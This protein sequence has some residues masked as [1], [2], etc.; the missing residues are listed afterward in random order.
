MQVFTFCKRGQLCD[1]SVDPLCNSV[2]LHCPVS[3]RLCFNLKY[4]K[5]CHSCKQNYLL[6][7]EVGT[8][9]SNTGYFTFWC[10]NPLYIYILYRCLVSRVLFPLSF[11]NQS[12]KWEY[13]L[14]SV[15]QVV[16]LFLKDTI[17]SFWLTTVSHFFL[18]SKGSVFKFQFSQQNSLLYFKRQLNRAHTFLKYYITPQITVY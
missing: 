2:W 13:Q 6:I 17:C 9:V 16:Y 4:F 3:S 11:A 5:G 12:S 10:V 18:F 15:S 14:L 1:N 7:A 8:T